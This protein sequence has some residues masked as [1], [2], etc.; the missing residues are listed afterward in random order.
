MGIDAGDPL[1]AKDVMAIATSGGCIWLKLFSF[2]THISFPTPTIAETDP[3]LH[4]D[5]LPLAS[6][7]AASDSSEVP[8]VLLA[9]GNDFLN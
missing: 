7:E 5:K 1:G 4:D 3:L 9:A 2:R 6:E 8:C